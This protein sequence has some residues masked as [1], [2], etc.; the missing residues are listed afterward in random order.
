MD[1]R[2]AYE[3][4]RGKEAK[5][6]GFEFGEGVMWKRRREGGPLRK[7]ACMWDDGVFLGVKGSTGEFIVGDGKGI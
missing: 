4:L 3:R 1:G 2:T 5:L 7:L 6:P